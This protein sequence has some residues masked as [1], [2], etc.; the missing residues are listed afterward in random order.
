MTN[1]VYET[2]N[3]NCIL[4]ITDNDSE[5]TVDFGIIKKSNYNPSTYKDQMIFSYESL[6]KIYLW[7]LN[8]KDN[9]YIQCN[10]F[11][12]LLELSFFESYT[13]TSSTVDFRV[14]ESDNEQYSDYFLMNMFE[15]QNFRKT[16]HDFL[17][18]KKLINN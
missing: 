13:L 7:L 4:L 2:T 5:F 9:L 10:C 17:V 11:N 6:R 12:E 8:P 16:L 15:V 18:I 1:K 3:E 14:Y